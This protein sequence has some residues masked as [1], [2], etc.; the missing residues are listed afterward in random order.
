MVFPIS[1]VGA[2][3]EKELDCLGMLEE[4]LH[5]MNIVEEEDDF[6]QNKDSGF[7]NDPDMFGWSLY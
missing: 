7:V 5:N 1:E 2:E 3:S 4:R 6:L